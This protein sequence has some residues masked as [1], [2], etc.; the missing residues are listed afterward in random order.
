MNHIKQDH[1][2]K[3]AHQRT[4][5]VLFLMC[6]GSVAIDQITKQW[7]ER[8]L[9]VW[10]QKENLKIYEGKRHHLL[11]LGDQE[12][13]IKSQKSF[14]SFNFNYVR[15][16]GAA[17]GMFSNLDDN[18]RIPF[19]YFVTI[20]AIAIII[21]YWR[22]TPLHHRLARFA[23]ALIFSG[24]IG[25]F[26]DRF[27]LDYVIDFIDVRWSFMLPFKI[28]LNIDFFP[29][30]LD[31]LNFKIYLEKWSYSFPNF[32]W[33]DSTITVGVSLLI[34]DM[35]VFEPAREKQKQMLEKEKTSLENTKKT[36]R[37]SMT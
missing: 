22:S 17:W 34:F 30:F 33:A 4:L 25:N 29:S 36:E 24:A 23:L 16:Q 28:N 12:E 15:N 26:I 11:T 3:K 10:E 8:Y 14:L 6:L 35:L 19:F 2:Q 7:A 20:F 5:F 21:F 27:R 13:S 9:M 31:F 32:N 37:M 1:I 18:I